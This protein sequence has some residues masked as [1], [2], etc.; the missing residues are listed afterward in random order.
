M[1]VS[2]FVIMEVLERS[3]REEGSCGD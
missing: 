1:K 3:L 2:W